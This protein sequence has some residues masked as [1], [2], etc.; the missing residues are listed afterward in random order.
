MEVGVDRRVTHAIFTQETRVRVETKRYRSF[1]KPHQAGLL[2]K[3]NQGDPVR[4]DKIYVGAQAFGCP[5]EMLMGRR[6][7][8]ATDAKGY[9]MRL[10]KV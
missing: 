2:P 5:T 1:P 6:S 7:V 10:D 8:S 9:L 3:L 4:Q